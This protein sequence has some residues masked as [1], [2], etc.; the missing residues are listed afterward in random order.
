MTYE[1]W[2]AGRRKK[3]HARLS[4]LT[5]EQQMGDRSAAEMAE[6]IEDVSRELQ[7]LDELEQPIESDSA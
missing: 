2:C 1:E 3:L 6:A 4:L 5:L 7:T